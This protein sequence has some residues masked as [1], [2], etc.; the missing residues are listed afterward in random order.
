MKTKKKTI[1]SD[2]RLLLLS[3]NATTITMTT[4]TTITPSNSVNV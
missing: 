2:Y 1:V 3:T 4:S